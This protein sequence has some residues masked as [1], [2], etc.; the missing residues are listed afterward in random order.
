MNRPDPVDYTEA[1]I[2]L[3]ILVIVGL[4]FVLVI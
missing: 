1:L 4:F 2:F 3:A